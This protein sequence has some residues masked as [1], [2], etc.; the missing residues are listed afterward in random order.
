MDKLTKV[1]RDCTISE[2]PNGMET[3][4]EWCFTNP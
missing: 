4:K 1:V 2:E 3:G